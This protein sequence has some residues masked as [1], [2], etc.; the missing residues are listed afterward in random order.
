MPYSEN[1]TGWDVRYLV[2]AAIFHSHRQVC[3]MVWM[4]GDLD[5]IPLLEFRWNQ[6][7]LFKRK[8]KLSSS[9]GSY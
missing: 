4:V 7:I 3:W 5:F 8:R 9:G 1:R 6:L 2:V